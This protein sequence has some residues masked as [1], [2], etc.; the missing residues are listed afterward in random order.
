MDMSLSKLW[1][2]VKDREAWDTAVHGVVKSWTQLS[3]WTTIS[4]K[5]F[6]LCSLFYCFELN[7]KV[8]FKSL[9]K[10]SLSL[11]K[12]NVINWI[13]GAFLDIFMSKVFWIHATKYKL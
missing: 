10:E 8:G 5:T 13:K 2:M 1:V 4:I 3:N 7:T 9:F 6:I 11:S 12:E